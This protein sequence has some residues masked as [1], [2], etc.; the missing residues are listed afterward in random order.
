VAYSLI[1]PPDEDVF[2]GREAELAR[3][4]DMIA[5]VG[6]GQPWL[7]T[8][9]GESGVG[10]TALVRRAVASSTGLRVLW[11]RADPA[12]VDLDY[13]LIE[14]LRRRVDSEVAARYPLLAGDLAQS[15]PFAVGAQLLGMIGD[16]QA[17]GP[18]AVVID[19]VQWADRRSVE[20]LSF[21]FRRLSV[22]PVLVIVLVRGIR[23]QL[24]EP[25]RRM[26][27]SVAQRQHLSLSGLSLD[28]ADHLAAALRAEPLGR[29]GLQRL[30]DR[31]GGHTLYLRTLLSDTEGLDRPGPDALAVPP[32]LAAT[33]G[34]QLAMLPAPT[35]S[36]LEMLAV[37]NARMPLA[38]LGE[39][40]GI[41][42]TSAAIEPAARAGLVD[43]WPHELSRPVEIRHALQR[44]A[45]Y[46]RMTA[47]RRRALH[48][49]AVPLVDEAAA[50][51]HRVASLDRP[52]E[53]LAGQ[54]E[55]R[56][57]EEAAGGRL[58]LAATHL[59]WASDLSPARPDR[60]RRLLIA[61]LHLML[62]EETRGLG[63]RQAVDAAAPSPLRS[64]VLGTMAFS[65]GQLGE[66]EHRFQEAL[67][68]ARIDPA[69]QPLAA[70]IANRLAGTYTL[71]GDG[72][73][74]AAYGRWALETGCLDAA[75]A[76]QTRT[77]IA[78]AA[79]QVSGPRDALAELQHLDDDPG[80]VDP[81][82]VDGLSFR[83]AFSLLA[84]DLGSAVGD[85]TAS[86]RMVRTGATITLGLRVYAYLALAQYLAGSWDDVLLTSE[87]GFSAAAIHAR[88][89]ELP[90]LHLAATCV[91]AGRGATLDAESHAG[92]AEEAAASLD[93]G[94]EKL[95]AGMARALVFQAAGD[96]LGMVDALK[97]GLDDAALDGR[98]RTYA[99]LWRP[100]LVEGLIGCGQFEEAAATL[101]L[102]RTGSG[103]VTYLE[104]A[105][106]WLSGWLAEQR[107]APEV[108]REIYQDGEDAASTQS[109]VYTARLLLAHGR[110]L[111]RIGQR[112][113]A[114]ERLRRA[115][116]LYLALGAAPFVARTEEELAACGLRQESSKRRSVLE[117]TDRETEVAHLIEKGM[118]NPEIAAELFITPKA[119]EYHLGNIYAK[120][121]LRGRQQLRRFLGESRRPAPA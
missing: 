10:K 110:L 55:R 104:P 71:L 43:L 65:S 70:I 67:A 21:T 40:A 54:L 95:Y 62:A 24:D 120:F 115:N 34:D 26:L 88:R 45:I 12:E 98:S 84:G 111:R 109:P 66:A 58:A 20:A 87:Q 72:E 73:K 6:Q 1:G 102:L 9:E 105:L 75:A 103:H 69:T 100:L 28:D 106:A 93:Y 89:F 2:V 81:V 74:V 36:L 53:H 59:Q 68:E 80:R 4:R 41:D 30:F 79:S 44:D 27:L 37:V 33:I 64:C 94:Q 85:M 112:R 52:D 47:E 116:H 119:V 16:Q 25:T 31:T 107:G 22:D 32:S 60:E 101:E 76:S 48:A 57:D 78:I 56:A 118:T 91:P 7:V 19:D 50:W 46:A 29:A 51:A 5:R 113:L 49:R 96:Y 77:L 114:V 35:R 117:M 14:Q 42:E 82:D 92:E 8:V 18:V 99:V 23:D 17:H 86:L 13:G 39:A 3:L 121:G 83:G 38:L 63:L 90:L 108:A 61:A 15:S 11:S 97:G